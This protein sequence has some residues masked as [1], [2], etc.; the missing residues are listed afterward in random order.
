MILIIGSNHD[1]VLYYHS[2]IKYPE[3][4]NLMRDYHAVTGT[5]FNSK[6]M[7]LEDVYTSYLSASLATYLIEKFF[8][9]VI[10]CVGKCEAISDNLKEGSIAVSNRVIFGDLNQIE[11]SKGTVLGQIPGLPK[12]YQPNLQLLETVNSFL[13]R[14]ANGNHFN[15]LFFSS[16]AYCQDM[17]MMENIAKDEKLLASRDNIVVDGETAGI[18]LACYLA[19]I[20]FISVKVVEGK[21]GVKLDINNYVKI[22]RQYAAVGKAVVSSIGEINRQDVLR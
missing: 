5:I 6:V 22:L 13:S 17:H 21:A 15:C 3:E 14:I 1:D 10:F 12:D 11:H 7:I 16:S 18:A 4:V 20:P 8:I 9:S 2:I 19:D